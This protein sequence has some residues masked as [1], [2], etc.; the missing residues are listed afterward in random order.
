MNNVNLETFPKQGSHLTF[1]DSI[2][3]DL[4]VEGA[5]LQVCHFLRIGAKN[6]EFRQCNLTQ[7]L[8]EDTYFRKAQFINVRLSK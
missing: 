2:K 8:F 7:C 4:N 3:D 6:A 5:S 1:C